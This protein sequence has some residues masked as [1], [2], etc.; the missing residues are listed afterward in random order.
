M[1]PLPRKGRHLRGKLWDKDR[2]ETQGVFPFD[3]FDFRQ[4][5]ASD[6][7]ASHLVS[8]IRS[9][10]LMPWMH[11][12]RS[13]GMWG[14]CKS[15]ASSLQ[16]VR[17]RGLTF[18]VRGL[19]QELFRTQMKFFR[20]W[21]STFADTQ[22]DLL[23]DTPG[24]YKDTGGPRGTTRIEVPANLIGEESNDK[25]LQEVHGRVVESS[26]KQRRDVSQED[27]RVMRA[28][29]NMGFSALEG[30]SPLELSGALQALPASSA[31]VRPSHASESTLGKMLGDALD[32]LNSSPSKTGSAADDATKA[33]D[34][35]RPAKV[36]ASENT[37]VDPVKRNQ[38]HRE[39]AKE[40]SNE[41]TKLETAVRQ[42]VCVEMCVDP[43][44][45][46]DGLATLKE[47]LSIALLHLGISASVDG[48]EKPPSELK[49][50]DV[51]FRRHLIFPWDPSLNNTC[52]NNPFKHW[53]GRGVRHVWGLLWWPE[54][55]PQIYLIR[56]RTPR[57]GMHI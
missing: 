38:L 54:S 12:S 24:I 9:S 40:H 49:P 5:E 53:C 30:S 45:D 29:A 3:L 8:V 21:S 20:G 39:Q 32:S 16:H 19:P 27:Y 1:T 55:F 4:N 57:F 15:I 43:V 31:T 37:M 11:F 52:H 13:P 42:A 50:M 14:A 48:T 51:V 35:Q 2:R 18:W 34:Q 25:S 36:E 28:E 46:A 23:A 41:K 26:S 22:F 44:V 33:G 17:S 6:K 56:S 7:L 47:R 10:A